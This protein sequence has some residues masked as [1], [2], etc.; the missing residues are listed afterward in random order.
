MFQ[1]VLRRLHKAAGQGS[2]RPVKMRETGIQMRACKAAFPLPFFGFAYRKVCTNL[3]GIPVVEF[4]DGQC[5]S[6]AEKH[7]VGL[8][9]HSGIAKAY[10][11]PGVV[12]AARQ[13]TRHGVNLAV[14]T[15]QRL[16]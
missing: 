16:P 6:G 13:H 1:K 12:P 3:R 4:V 10:Q 15:L 8:C 5:F 11:P 2:A 14:H 9:R 7:T